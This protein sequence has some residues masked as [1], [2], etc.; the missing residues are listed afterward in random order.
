MR[1]LLKL[2]G[3]IFL[4]VLI[5]TLASCL[6]FDKSQNIFRTPANSQVVGVYDDFS[7]KGFEES[8]HRLMQEGKKL[9]SEQIT[10]ELAGREIW[11]KSAPNSRFHTYIFGPRVN[12]PIDWYKV[13][14]SDQ[15]WQRFYTWGLINDP[16]C[17]HPSAD[18][19]DCAQKHLSYRGRAVT[20][21]DTYGFD[22]C[23]GDDE[24]LSF[25]GKPE[26]DYSKVDPACSNP[27][28][29]AADGL[30]QGPL[31]S[32]CHLAFGTSTGAVGFRKFPNPRF[33]A[34]RW[35]KINVTESENANQKWDGYSWSGFQLR[36]FDA[37]VEP[38]FR[39]AISCASCH[40]SFEPTRPPSDP[41]QP[42]WFNISGTVGAQYIKISQIL[43][44]GTQPHSLEWQLFVPMARPGTSD[45]SAIPNDLISNPGTI[46][47]VINLIQRPTFMDQISR[48]RSVPTCDPQKSTC[49]SVAYNVD[50]NGNSNQ[51]KFWE[52]STKTESTFHILKG[53]EDS[54]QPDLA[55]QR[56]Y[57]NIGMCA[58][59]CWMN[60][61]TDL[62]ALSS[63][64]RGFK[65]TP[66]DIAQC[67][68]DCAPWRANEDRVGDIFAFL[69]SARPSDLKEALKSTGDVKGQSEEEVQA[70]FND[71][72]ENRFKGSIEKGRNLF[73]RNCAGCHSSANQSKEDNFT[74]V[75]EDFTNIDFH[76][77]VTLS[78][79]EIVRADWMGNDKSTSADL[80][81]T[82]RCRSL[83]SNHMQG[84]LWSQ[85]ASETYKAKP[86]TTKDVKG[87]WIAGGPGYYRNISLLSAWA[88]APFMHNNAVGPEICGRPEGMEDNQYNTY[89]G[90]QT[91]PATSH[92]CDMRYDPSVKSRLELFDRSMDELLT[93]P[94][95]RAKKITRAD[96]NIQV[97][98]GMSLKGLGTS[99]VRKF[100][101]EFPGGTPI[102]VIG[103]LDYKALVADLLG[104]LPLIDKA[105]PDF[106]NYWNART[107]PNCGSRMA[108]AVRG[109]MKLIDSAKDLASATQVQDEIHN[110]ILE[111][112]NQ[113][114]KVYEECYSTCPANYE[115]LGHR[116][117]TNASQDEKN[118]LKAFISTL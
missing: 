7:A 76:R 32:S 67:R 31:E 36:R 78:S 27:S 63:H 10:K 106:E 57:V 75:S 48:W 60:H 93:P 99:P 49:Q 111:N 114:L 45:T 95:S 35:N 1:K 87:R 13:M 19:K 56:V 112:N 37:S 81:G 105:G 17:C 16:D 110:S 68:R 89:E 24:L 43:G 109:T 92:K 54:V 11:Y 117:M 46:N 77:Q 100:F 80:V 25:V 18:N 97:P 40:A 83:H 98:L 96:A 108:A 59:Q 107:G 62:R 115:N 52:W 101:L 30:K 26:A 3:G 69:I 15:R 5:L 12:A 21:Q 20:V 91:N 116:F 42:K 9:S 4:P 61:H 84:H 73:A 113:R 65:Q 22:Y 74:L 90:Q 94:E 33:N 53:G 2:R 14:R 55:V 82:D 23:P 70:N 58:E 66:F 47:A 41:N 79:G 8:N 29:K 38:P 6:S 104:S 118:A 86:A 102:G 72:V 85:F 50:V 88:F 71:F 51:K 28:I 34:T 44:S 64:D 39:V 103:S